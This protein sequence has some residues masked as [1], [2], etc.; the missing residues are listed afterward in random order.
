MLL[1][2][3]RKKG[4]ISSLKGHEGLRIVQEIYEGESNNIVVKYGLRSLTKTSIYSS[5]SLIIKSN[6]ISDSTNNNVDGEYCFLRSCHLCHKQFL[7]NQDVYMYRG[8]LGFCCVECRNKQI[9][10]DER[11]EMEA[12]YK[13]RVAI[14]PID[15]RGCDTC[16]LLQ[17]LRQRRKHRVEHRLPLP[18]LSIS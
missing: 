9:M 14:S 13:K 2:M 1:M 15:C 5:P 7:P 12:K 3:E 17:D 8:D 10:L 4:G 18:L 11:K 6:L 16:K